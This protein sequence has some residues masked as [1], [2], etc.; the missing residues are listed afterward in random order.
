SAWAAVVSISLM[1]SAYA[2]DELET[3]H[4]FGFTQGTDVNDVGE[5][6]AESEGTGRFGKR[7]GSYAALS[8][9]ASIKF[10]PFRDFSVEPGLGVAY[11][12]VSG[13]P[14]LDDRRQ[15]AVQSFSLETRY[16]VFNREHAPFGLTF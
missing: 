14:G 12:D 8:Q 6:E 4:L 10:I 1:T 15:L 11:H 7:A 3:T 2:K 5:T 9:E 16:R 13:V